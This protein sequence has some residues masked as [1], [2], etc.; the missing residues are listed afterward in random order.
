[1]TDPLK[2]IKFDINQVL[3]SFAPIEADES[4]DSLSSTTLLEFESEPIEAK[5]PK[6]A[7]DTE[8]FSDMMDDLPAEETIVAITEKKSLEVEID[9]FIKSTITT[10]FNDPLD[11]WRTSE[12]FTL[13]K[14]AFKIFNIPAA[15]A[16]PERHNSAAGLNMTDL[17]NQINPNTLESFVIYKCLLN[18]N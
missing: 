18:E 7:K 3:K 17:R 13:K 11:F 4:I 12:H 14:I 5:V 8:D 16:E 2:D 6:N 15:S 10:K 9:E 1:M